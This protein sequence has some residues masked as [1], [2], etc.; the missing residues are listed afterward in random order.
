MEDGFELLGCRRGRNGARWAGPRGSVMV[1]FLVIFP[2]M[3]LVVQ[4]AVWMPR[5]IPVGEPVDGAIDERRENP[6]HK[7]IPIKDQDIDLS[8]LKVVRRVALVD[9]GDAERADETDED[10]LEPAPQPFAVEQEP[11][12]RD[13]ESNNRTTRMR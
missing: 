13:G 4:I 8:G 6:Q 7:E 12:D 5:D 1:M 11:E 3:L 2:Q 9:D 10:D